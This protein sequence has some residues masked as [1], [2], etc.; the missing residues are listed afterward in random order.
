MSSHKHLPTTNINEPGFGS[1]YCIT[2][3]IN[4]KRYIGQ[5][6]AEYVSARWSEHKNIAKNNRSALPLYKDMQSYG[7]DNFIFEVLLDHVPISDLDNK[8]VEYIAKHNCRIPNGYNN[9][10]G[11]A[12]TP[13]VVPWNKG[14][15]RSE[16]T[17][18]KLRDAFTS[19]RRQLAS[20]RV[21]G[22]NNPMYGRY[23]ELNPA[24]GLRLCGSDNGFYGKHHS[25]ATRKIISD[26]QLNK[27]PVAMLDKYSEE[28]LM[29]FN[30]IGEARRYLQSIGFD[31]ADDSLIS[32]CARGI[33]KHG[34]GYKW[35]FIGGD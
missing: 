25:K 17:K 10:I 28:V 27:K 7:V 12:G 32:G 13:G 9:A 30:S 35:K 2:N 24:Y 23:G 33:Y 6:A 31:K 8:E 19:E 22:K 21:S 20:Q 14:I 16:D 5:T 15:P 18:Q 29:E 34:Y 11:G 1:I 4:G 26:K 3:K